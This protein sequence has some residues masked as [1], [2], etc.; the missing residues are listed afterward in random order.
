MRNSGSNF[1]GVALRRTQ[2]AMC[3]SVVFAFH[4]ALAGTVTVCDDSGV[5]GTLRNVVAAAASAENISVSNCSTI[6]LTSGEIASSLSRLRITGNAAAPTV[7]SGNN[8]SR[9]IN[10]TGSGGYLLLRNV[11]IQNGNRTAA[12]ALGG[13]IYSS[14]PIVTLDHATVKNCTATETSAGG[15]AEGG[16]VFAA[17]LV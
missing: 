8:N 5:A 13:C 4:D 14:A 15:F 11:T 3:L 6:T 2:L 16:G 1:S 7:I 12:T 17:H 10:H 9:V